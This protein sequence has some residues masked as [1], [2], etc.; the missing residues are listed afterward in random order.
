MN[1][2]TLNIV[3]LIIE[4]DK[5]MNEIIQEVLIPEGYKTDCVVSANEAVNIIKQNNGK[6]QLLILDYNL[7]DSNGT[8]GLD[9]FETAKKINPDVKGILIT[10]Y[11]E[12]AIVERSRKLGISKFINKPFLITDLIDSVNELAGELNKKNKRKQ[13]FF[14]SYIR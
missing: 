8:T 2:K 1:R 12:N 5:F 9:V 13:N 7:E 6:Y 11:T 14:E 3:I 10:A 4:D